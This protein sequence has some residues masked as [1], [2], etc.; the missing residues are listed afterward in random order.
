MT[1]ETKINRLASALEL[2]VG[3]SHLEDLYDFR[4]YLNNKPDILSRSRSIA[5]NGFETLIDIHKNKK[6]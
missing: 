3:V 5:L 4:E 6:S 2:F 1:D